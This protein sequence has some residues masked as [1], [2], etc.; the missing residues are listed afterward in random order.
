MTAKS[1][2]TLEDDKKKKKKKEISQREK[3][4]EGSFG[5]NE[6][7]ELLNLISELPW[8]FRCFKGMRMHSE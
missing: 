6:D 1:F 3:I 5:N 2:S 8:H 7:H 4:I